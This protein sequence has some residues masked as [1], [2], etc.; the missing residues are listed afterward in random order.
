MANDTQFD[1]KNWASSIECGT[2]PKGE[3]ASRPDVEEVIQELLILR[4]KGKTGFSIQQL[5]E[6]LQKEFGLKMSSSDSLRTTIKKRM[7]D[8]YKKSF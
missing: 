1:V 8:L 5:H 2:P 4:S 6:M 3:L 7:P